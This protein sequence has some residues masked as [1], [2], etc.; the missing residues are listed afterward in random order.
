MQLTVYF[1]AIGIV[2]GVAYVRTTAVLFAGLRMLR[3]RKRAVVQQWG[4][5]EIACIPE[6]FLLPVVTY[7]VVSGQ[8]APAQISS[9]ELAAACLG[10]VLALTGGAIT[11]WALAAFPSVTTG[12]YILDDHPL[13]TRGPY[14]WVR[15]PIYL[16]VFLIWL[17]LALGSLS[18]LALL[19][20]ALYVVPIYVLYMRS[21]EA[22]LKAHLGEPYRRYFESVG[23][24]LPRIGE[25]RS[26]NG[27]SVSDKGMT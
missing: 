22:M 25:D 27:G 8:P 15:H 23:M 5:V 9:A 13:V 7:A 4:W 3:N 12:H 1:I 17:S 2:A 10:A 21:E 20:T 11:V 19:I 18:F 14:G 24:L 16:G 26:S 6:L